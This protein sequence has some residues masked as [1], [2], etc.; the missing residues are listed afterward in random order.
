[1]FTGIIENTGNVKSIS[2]QGA[3][4]RLT[5]NIDTA[6]QLKANSSLAIDG[7]CLTVID[8]TDQTASFDIIPETLSKTTLGQLQVGQPV[9]Y[10]R[11]LVFGDRLDGHLTQGHVDC[12]T[13]VQRVIKEDGEYKIWFTT[14]AELATSITKHG[15][16]AINGVSLTVADLEPGQFSVALIS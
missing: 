4:L 13:P 11:S 2:K 12:T 5:V 8:P 10:E 3:H 9:N 15:S 1:M 6:N 16:I 14:P 7:V